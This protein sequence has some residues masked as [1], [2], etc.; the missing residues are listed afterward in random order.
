MRESFTHC[1]G[2]GSGTF[3][4]CTGSQFEFRA[5][6]SLKFPS[7]VS[8]MS[9]REKAQTAEPLIL[10]T[11]VVNVPYISCADTPPYWPDI[12]SV[13]DSVNERISSGI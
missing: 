8:A 9:C 7:K 12:S 5:L 10:L 11:G 3:A 4:L 1:P 6:C 2:L 13:V